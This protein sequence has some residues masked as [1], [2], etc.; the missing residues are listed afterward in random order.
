[1][2][3]ARI[4]SYSSASSL[5]TRFC[6]S[7]QLHIYHQICTYITA[8]QW[9]GPQSVF[10]G[11]Q[12]R[13]GVSI[14]PHLVAGA[15]RARGSTNVPSSAD[16]SVAPDLGGGTSLPVGDG[17]EDA[18]PDLAARVA[19]LNLEEPEAD[20]GDSNEQ[21]DGVHGSQFDW[22]ANRA[23]WKQTPIDQPITAKFA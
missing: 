20:A 18:V 8:T 11:K 22:T 12:Q 17:I 2:W 16:E 3:C 19:A 5:F 4:A 13:D 1:M 15:W 6:V 10:T 23:V 9:D 7:V 21:A 14:M